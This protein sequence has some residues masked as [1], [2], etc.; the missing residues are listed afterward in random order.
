MR[1]FFSVVVGGC[2]FGGWFCVLFGF[3]VLGPF[4]FRIVSFPSLHTK[5]VEIFRS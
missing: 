5:A 3:V 2:L 4:C 1:L